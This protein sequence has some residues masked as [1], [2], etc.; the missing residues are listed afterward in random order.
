MNMSS[1]SGLTVTSASG[2]MYAASK[3]AL[4][5][6]SEGLH[7][8]L[9]HF[10]VR[11]IIIEPGLFRT[12]WLAGSYVTPAKGLEK[13]Y[14]GT[15]VSDALTQYPTIH[16]MQE[17]DPSKAAKAIVEMA[18]GTG[19]GARDGMKASLRL[20]LGGDA[21]DKARDYVKKLSAE[22]DAVEGVARDMSVDRK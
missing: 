22:L 15:P 3:F 19:I 2:T 20:P 10:G 13:D 16:G 4:E 1:I 5:A 14:I 8:Q 9:K 12:N 7:A 11:V 17:G 21:M 18:T 6:V